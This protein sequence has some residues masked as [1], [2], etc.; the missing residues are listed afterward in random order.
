MNRC[1]PLYN[2]RATTPR[3]PKPPECILD[4]QSPTFANATSVS[5][6]LVP[7]F[8]RTYANIYSDSPNSNVSSHSSPLSILKSNSSR[9]Q[10]HD[11]DRSPDSWTEL[12]TRIVLSLPF[13]L[14]FLVLTRPIAHQ[15]QVLILGRYLRVKC[16]S[17]FLSAKFLLLMKGQHEHNVQDSSRHPRL[18][19]DPPLVNPRDGDGDGDG[20]DE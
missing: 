16:T 6:Q 7:S 5:H 1:R 10:E 2:T 8:T 14:K 9:D 15:Q 13:A 11:H 17:P 4:F 12:S 19:H 3:P 18:R 20:G